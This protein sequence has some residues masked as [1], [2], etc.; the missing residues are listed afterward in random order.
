MPTAVALV[1]TLAW[2]LTV[3]LLCYL[4]RTELRSIARAIEGRIKSETSDISIGPSGLGIT[5]KVEAITARMESLEA[6]QAQ[7]GDV[8]VRQ[9]ESADPDTGSS[10]VDKLA[11]LAEQYLAINEPDY[12]ER[13]SL[14]DAYA[15]RLGIAA[16]ESHIP[17]GTLVS[18]GNE[19]YVLALASVILFD[20]LPDDADKLLSAGAAISRLHVRYYVSLALSKLMSRGLVRPAQYAEVKRL[21]DLYRITADEPLLRRLEEATAQFEVFVQQA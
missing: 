10:T 12:N 19:A 4:L 14:K 15:R 13:V 20:P 9:L 21:L 6:G 1:S 17:R 7:Y 2:P 8:I 3:L 11:R 5:T 16:I 18:S